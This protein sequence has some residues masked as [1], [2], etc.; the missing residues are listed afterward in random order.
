[1]G[2]FVFSAFFT[3]AFP[4]RGL[5]GATVKKLGRL[6]STPQ[7]RAAGVA[8]ASLAGRVGYIP[9]AWRARASALAS[10]ALARLA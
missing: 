6:A 2:I 8:R 5:Y 1:M 4:M 10:P 9:A 3:F 7:A